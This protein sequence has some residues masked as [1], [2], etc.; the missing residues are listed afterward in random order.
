MEVLSAIGGVLALLL[1]L[2]REFFDWRRRKRE[3]EARKL[4]VLEAEARAVQ[5]AIEAMRLIARA[6]NAGAVAVE[7]ALDRER[8]ARH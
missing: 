7:D 2:A 1:V 5:K 3:V 6:E 8:R 4:E